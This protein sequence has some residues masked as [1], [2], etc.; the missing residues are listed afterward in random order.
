MELKTCIIIT[1]NFCLHDLKIILKVLLTIKF[2]ILIYI[3]YP[4]L[5]LTAPGIIINRGPIILVNG[6]KRLMAS[7]SL[8]YIIYYSLIFKHKISLYWQ[9]TLVNSVFKGTFD[10][11]FSSRNL[12]YIFYYT[13]LISTYSCS[14]SVVSSF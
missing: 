4:N 14:F 3:Y 13:G 7:I 6:Y 1:F 10:C 8:L 11:Q 9:F 12:I 2:L 5:Q